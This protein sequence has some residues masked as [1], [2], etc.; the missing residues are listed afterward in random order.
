VP[1][2]PPP[3]VVVVGSI[4]VDLVVAVTRLPA[5]GETVAGGRFA[6]FGGVEWSARSWSLKLSMN[7]DSFRVS[8]VLNLWHKFY[9]AFQI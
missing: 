1:S 4:N 7:A 8:A 6:Q 3:R 2:S 5:A 9:R